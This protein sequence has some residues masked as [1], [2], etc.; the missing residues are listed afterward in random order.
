MHPQ[1]AHSV[2]LGIAFALLAGLVANQAAA[3][4]GPAP[5]GKGELQSLTALTDRVAL[6]EQDQPQQLVITGHYSNGGVRDLTTEAAFRAG[7][8]TVVRI[9][10]G[11]LL[12]ALKNGTTEVT[13]EAGGKTVKVPVSVTG[14]DREQPINFA[15]EVVP[16][17]SKLGC[18]SG[19]CHGKASGQNGFKLSLLGFEPRVDYDALTREARGRRLFLAA[20]KAS[21]LLLKATGAVPHGGGKRLDPGSRDYQLL[22]RWIRSGT[23]IGNS[24][25]PRVVGITVAPDHRLVAPRSRQQITVTARYSDGS[26]R[27]VTSQ[28]EYSSNETEV[29]EVDERGL[30]ETRDIPGEGSVMVRYLGHVAVFRATIPLDTPLARFPQH[31]PASFTDQH[32]FARLKLLGVPPSGLCTDSEFLRRVSLDITGTLPTAA[33]A[34]KFLEDRNPRKRELLVDALLEKRGYASYFALKWGDILRNRRTGVVR[35]GG[36]SARTYAFHTWIRESLAKNKPYDQFVREIITAK[37]NAV[38]TGAQP[39]VGWYHVLSTPQ[40]LADDTAQAFLGTRI[41]CAQCHHHPYEKWSQDDYWGLAAFFSRVERKPLKT[42]VPKD[43]K[44]LLT[45]LV[46]RDGKV[47][48]PQGKA[49][50][51]PRP[52]GGEEVEVPPGADPRERLAEWMTR[53]DNPFLARALVNRYWAHFFGRGI[54]EMADDI[55]VTNPASNPALLDALAKNF[56]EHRFDLKYLIRTI[57]TSKTYQL[58]CTPNEYNRKDRQNFARFYPRRLPAEVL[59]DA[60]DQ[61]TDVRTRFRSRDD[62]ARAIELP[63]ESVRSS[64]LEVFGKPSRDSACE[65]ERVSAATLAQSLY[66]ITSDEVHGKLK[67]TRSRAAQLA[68]DSR[69]M[70]ERIRE[71]FLWV[72]ARYPTAEELKTAEA[73]LTR[74]ESGGTGGDRSKAGRQQ[75]RQWPYEDLLW[76]LL[77]T[78]EFLFN[79]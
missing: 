25:D 41:Q 48:S 32:V 1:H 3:A 56:V 15:N 34:R 22:L 77:N 10:K 18:N 68:A 49:Y 75:A 26:Q 39:P 9:E 17:F 52:L 4:E 38:G 44:G 42:K 51:R 60:L 67:N 19:G 28:A 65:C 33:E 54:V 11:G 55:R 73:F 64:F 8:P 47:T 29:V 59:L 5:V 53:P 7:D 66:L 6:Q 2:I 14:A 24:T 40:M 45:I 12:V 69:P 20:P 50:P 37:G 31:T 43:G 21:L 57:C 23:P 71:I 74:E 62:V 58:S 46:A 78:K 76:A 61:I 72:Y 70:A 79:H 35:L 30:V 16:V 63:D 13:A 36:G 27:D